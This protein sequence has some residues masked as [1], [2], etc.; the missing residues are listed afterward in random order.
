MASTE[1]LVIT[2]IHCL[3][4]LSN[5]FI[6]EFDSRTSTPAPG[7]RPPLQTRNWLA[8][9]TATSTS[10]TAVATTE[11]PGPSVMPRPVLH[12]LNENSL[13]KLLEFEAEVSKSV[14]L[15]LKPKVKV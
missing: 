9:S 4:T 8:P 14:F 15:T 5:M 6:S 3:Y 1:L 10:S 11:N 13:G 2:K 7:F 12:P